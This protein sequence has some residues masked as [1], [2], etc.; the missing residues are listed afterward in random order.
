M[1]VCNT[2]ETEKKK[3]WGMGDGDLNFEIEMG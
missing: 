3:G 1:C 2:W